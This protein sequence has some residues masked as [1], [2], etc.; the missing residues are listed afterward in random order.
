MLEQLFSP[1]IR[2]R[3]Q[4]I[5]FMSPGKGYNTHD[6]ARTLAENY[7]AI[8]KELVRLAKIG[9]LTSE[10]TP[11]VKT[12]NINPDCPIAP[13]LRSMIA[14]TAG[15]EDVMRAHLSGLPAVRAAFI[16]GSYASG[17]AGRDKN[18]AA[19]NLAGDVD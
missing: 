14:R 2:S 18:A 3:L 8:W 12:D 9:I 6:L 10:Q 4:V 11:C 17:E 16:Y 19:T 7:S 5:F 15:M 1:R 13:G